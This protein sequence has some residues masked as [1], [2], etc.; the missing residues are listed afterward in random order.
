ME[1]FHAIKK[2][3][4]RLLI[5]LIVVSIAGVIY[6]NPALNINYAN[7]RFSQ[8]PF[9]KESLDTWA[10][11]IKQQNIPE[12]EENSINNDTDSLTLL[13][14][15][16]DIANEYNQNHLIKISSVLIRS[17]NIKNAEIDFQKIQG[18]DDKYL[19]DKEYILSQGAKG[20]RQ[21][22]DLDLMVGST[23]ISVS[24]F[25]VQNVVA[26]T[27]EVKLKGEKED[28]QIKG[29]IQANAR[30]LIDSIKEKDQEG[31]S[32]LTYWKTQD[33]YSD[34][35]GLK[36][37]QTKINDTQISEVTLEPNEGSFDEIV[38]FTG[39]KVDNVR[40][41]DSTIIPVVYDKD[42]R[43][44][45]FRDV[46]GAIKLLCDDKDAYIPP[47]SVEILSCDDCTY[48]PVD[49]SHALPSTYTPKVVATGLSG[50]GYLTEEALAAAKLLFADAKT[51]GYTLTVVSAYRSYD[52]QIATFAYWTQREIAK[53]ASKVIAEERA[54]S[55][56]ARPGQSEHQLGT[57][58]DL[59][60]GNCASFDEPCNKPVY[61]YLEANSYK[62]GFIVSYPD[63]S[64]ELTGYKHE[65][66]H[67]RY[68]GVDLAKEYQPKRDSDSNFYLAKYLLQK[69]L[70]I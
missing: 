60:N 38:E 61:D 12:F 40:C 36:D 53:G 56:S 42:K 55:Y 13:E 32:K 49:K 16:A 17:K 62:F 1:N 2:N 69:K 48:A 52:T 14:S 35:Q 21:L 66:W 5:V 6:L 31:F 10:S 34:I 33:E 29:E 50:G 41:N 57:T 64:L 45:L 51:H 25:F 58:A 11:A 19:N 65:A 18:T 54:N 24:D 8:T 63:N 59:G 47:D 3:I 23:G 26:P 39:V 15:Y 67:L 4:Q 37:L 20:L 44:F 22:V 9:S 30:D 7:F 68:I 28:E 43:A 46:L 27:D 70:Y